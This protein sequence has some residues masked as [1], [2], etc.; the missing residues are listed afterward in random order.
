[1]AAG[2]SKAS[3]GTDARS[4]RVATIRPLLSTS[5]DAELDLGRQARIHVELADIDDQLEVAR[6]TFQRP[7]DAGKQGGV[8]EGAQELYLHDLGQ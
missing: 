3:A 8:L 5:L 6:R 1:M 4:T 2:T 7:A